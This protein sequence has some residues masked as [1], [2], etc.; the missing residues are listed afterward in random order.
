MGFIVMTFWVYLLCAAIGVYAVLLA[1]LKPKKEQFAGMLKMGLFLALLDFA[2]ENWGAWAGYWTS[3]GSLLPIAAVPTEVFLIAFCAGAVYSLLFPKKF[4]WNV[5]LP[6][7][8]LIA[9]IGAGVE[10]LLIGFELLA[11]SGGWTSFHALIAYFITFL[12]MH[13]ANSVLARNA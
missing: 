12:I 2:F 13:K 11:Y 4:D 8:F 6:S 9:V 1:L 5:A 7:S 3:T 10:A